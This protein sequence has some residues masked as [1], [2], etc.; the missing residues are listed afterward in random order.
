[1]IIGLVPVII[2]TVT[3]MFIVYLT[4]CTVRSLRVTVTYIYIIYST[5]YHRRKAGK[6]SHKLGSCLWQM[7][8]RKT[9]EDLADH[10]QGR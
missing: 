8:T 2:V 3:V 1:M 9:T 10:F 5:A 6:C 7:T 4:V